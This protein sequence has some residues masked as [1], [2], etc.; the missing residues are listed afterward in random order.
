MSELRR[1]PDYKDSG[2]PWLGEIP[3]H[4]DEKRMRFFVNTNPLK[5]E[6]DV[7][8]DTMVSFLP[9]EALSVDGGMN[10]DTDKEIGE[11]YKGYTYFR[12]DDV[13]IAKITPCFE[14]G[15]ASISKNLT[16]G[17]GFGTT[18]LHVLRPKTDAISKF[19]FYLIRSDSFMKIGESEMYG[20]GGQKRIPERFIKNFLGALPPLDEQ[21]AIVNFLDTELEHIDTLIDKQQQLIEKLAEQRSAVITHAITKGLDS[22]V[23]MKDSGVEWLGEI[24]EHWDLTYNK[25]LFN[26]SRGLTI[27]KADLI[28]EGIPCISYGEVH[29]KYGFEV[30]PDIHPLKCVPESYA[31]NFKY[32]VLKQGDFVFADTSEDY[33][34]SGN[35]THL[36]TQT[37]TMA[38]YHTVVMK[39]K[40]NHNYRYLA[41]M[42]DSKAFRTQVINQVSGVKVFSVTQGILKRTPAWLPPRIEQDKIVV[43]LDKETNRMDLSSKAATDIIA[44]LQEYRAALVTQ[45]VTGK[46]D[47]RDIDKGNSIEEVA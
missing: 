26:F 10:L 45:A 23:A 36:N 11:V 9:M 14:N 34:G 42:F 5:S 3:S 27:T 28:D 2:V 46:I 35:F 43:Y 33:K 8:D 15:K 13:V 12:N 41:Y 18:E 39:Q 6:L 17:I 30:D 32:A 16:N 20:A 38:G 21:K 37:M 19:I 29:S 31:E 44:K 24:P 1:Y 7:A 4:W 47:V 25:Y 22:D 40:H